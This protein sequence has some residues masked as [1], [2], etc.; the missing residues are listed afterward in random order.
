MK[1]SQTKYSASNASVSLSTRC[2]TLLNRSTLD[3]ASSILIDIC[4]LVQLSDE[5]YVS[6]STSFRPLAVY[7]VLYPIDQ[8]AWSISWSSWVGPEETQFLH[9]FPPTW[10][11]RFLFE[12]Q[13]P[14]C[15]LFP[16]LSERVMCSK[17]EW[18]SPVSNIEHHAI[19]EAHVSYPFHEASRATAS[20]ILYFTVL[21]G[22]SS[23]VRHNASMWLDRTKGKDDRGK[24]R[25]ISHE[26][27]IITGSPSRQASLAL[28][29]L[30]T[31]P[32]ALDQ[33][34]SII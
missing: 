18:G 2:R 4:S 30:G 17:P 5:R 24:V 12:L 8:L 16:S 31:L 33:L 27:G 10:I 3:S 14:S 25:I 13:R 21:C 11:P 1:R 9:L 29:L 19:K 34:I 23:K 22:K 28:T 7:A 20:G 15:V 32:A 26:R 6:S